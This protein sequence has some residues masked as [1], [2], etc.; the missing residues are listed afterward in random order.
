MLKNLRFQNIALFGNK[1]IDFQKG[2]TVFTGQSGSGKSIF[3]GTLNALLASKK[4][5]LD[6]QLVAKG[7]EFSSIEGVFFVSQNIK[8]WLINK[9]FDFDEELVVSREWRWKENKYKSRFRI[10][11]SLVN[12]DQISELRSLILDFTLQGDTYNL[13]DSSL[14]LS[15]LDSLG[16][17]IVQESISKVRQD[18]KIWYNANLNLQEARDK[19]LDTKK[20]FEDMQYI[21]QDLDNLGLEDPNEQLNLEND[22]NRLSNIL[23]LKEGVQALLMRLN[24]SLDEYPSISDHTNFC[25]NELKLMTQIDSA[26]ESIFDSFYTLTNHVNDLIYQIN[27]YEKTLDVDPSLLNDLQLRLSKLKFYQKKYNRNLSDLINYKNDLNSRLSLKESSNDINELSSLEKK[28]RIIRDKSNHDLSVLRKTVALQLEDKLIMSLKKLGI[29]NVRF[30]VVFEQREATINGIDK[31]KFLFSSNPGFPLAP[32]SEAASGGEKSRVLL[33][34]K[35]IFSSFDQTNLLIFDEIDS[36][37]SGSISSYVARLLLELSKH[38][39]VF[40][41]THQPLI[42]AF[43]D[44]HIALKKT[45]IA[46]STKS[47]VIKLKEIADR[48]R[49]L[50]LLAGGETVEANA[51]AASLLEHKAA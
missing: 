45:V 17:K 39:Q 14:Q 32:L 38:R 15:L 2:F 48:Q 41:V 16:S 20:Q 34:I 11:G 36:G 1:D 8:N 31:V 50:A 35:A 46:G 21:Y 49:E 18:W 3:I 7:S 25:I 22:Q 4:T 47:N 42:A 28:K 30:K 33:A 12:R 6:N 27:D 44:N 9:E 5:S 23:R 10:N 37:V 19:I 43:A 29:P 40:C 26:L 51:Y 13:N 24:E